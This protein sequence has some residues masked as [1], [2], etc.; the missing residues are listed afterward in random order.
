MGEWGRRL[1]DNDI[2]CDVKDEF[3]KLYREKKSAQEITEIMLNSNRDTLKYD[4]EAPLFWCALA[5]MQWKYGVLLP[6]VKEQALEWIGKLSG[7]SYS[8]M[9][10]LQEQLNSPLPPVKKVRKRR[11]YRCPWNIG[12]TFAYKPESDLAKEKGL[13]GRYLLIQKID[14]CDWYPEHII[15]IVYIKI[16]KDDKLP[17][18]I[19]E[20]NQLEY[21]QTWFLKYEQRFF[22]LDFSRLAE[23]I[24][25]K[26]KLTYEVDECGFLPLFRA[27]LI[28]VPKKVIIPKLSF[29]GNF[30]DAVRPN[31][32]FVQHSK[33]SVVPFFA[34]QFEERVLTSYFNMNCGEIEP[35]AKRQKKGT[36]D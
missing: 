2:T 32:E 29:V 20:Y 8:F 24:A 6:E 18:N 17:T 19:E 3:E 4:D 35:Y 1:Y 28:C 11:L 7:T 16:T 14:E 21:V 34:K 23:D 15:P 25:E 33:S 26:S 12:D 9:T 36:P 27:K 13:Y 22:P 5:D 31:K 30:A 10:K